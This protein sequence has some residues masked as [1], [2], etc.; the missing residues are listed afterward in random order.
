[1][2]AGFHNQSPLLTV[3]CLRENFDFFKLPFLL[4]GTAEFQFNIQISMKPLDMDIQLLPTLTKM[5]ML[6][7]IKKSGKLL[8]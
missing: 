8:F 2:F 6:V 1:M 3:L 4:T 5:E 7:K